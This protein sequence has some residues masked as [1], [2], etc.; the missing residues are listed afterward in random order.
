MIYQPSSLVQSAGDAEYTDSIIANRKDSPND[1]LA[2]DT[3]RS[4]GEAQVMLELWG[5]R[6]TPSVLSLPGPHWPGVKA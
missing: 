5:I 6:S 2:Y 3:K 1:C 4:D